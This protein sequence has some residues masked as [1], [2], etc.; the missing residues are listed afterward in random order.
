MTYSNWQLAVTEDIG[1]LEW[2]PMVSSSGFAYNTWVLQAPHNLH[3]II[4]DYECIWRI[5]VFHENTEITNA[6]AQ[7]DYMMPQLIR[8]LV[9][10]YTHHNA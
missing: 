10:H 8:Y 5:K 2:I 3:F 4:S 6:K 1:P 7:Y 9:K